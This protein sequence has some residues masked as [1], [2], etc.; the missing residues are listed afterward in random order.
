[1]SSKSPAPRITTNV[2]ELMSKIQKLGVTQSIQRS[3][4]NTAVLFA[5][6]QHHYHHQSM[7]KPVP[8]LEISKNKCQ[9]LIVDQNMTK[10]EIVWKI[11]NPWVSWQVLS[12]A[13]LMNVKSRNHI[14][15]EF[16]IGLRNKQMMIA[17]VLN[18]II[19]LGKRSSDWILSRLSITDWT[20]YFG[21]LWKWCSVRRISDPL[22]S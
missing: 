11:A 20:T 6:A 1:M 14:G 4:G 16:W 12:N 17:P 7:K 8:D 18:A 19:S 15:S 21:M 13:A 5:Q 3:D 2:P 9:Q 22:A 10:K